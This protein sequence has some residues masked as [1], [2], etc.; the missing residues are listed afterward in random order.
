MKRFLSRGILALGIGIIA[1][2]TSHPDPLNALSLL[3]NL[4]S[5]SNLYSSQFP[6][7][8]SSSP[9]STTRQEWINPD[10]LRY[11]LIVHDLGGA[12]AIGDQEETQR[13]NDAKKLEEMV[14]KTY[15]VHTVLLPLFGNGQD[16]DAGNEGG[17]E[18]VK[19][20]QELERL[21]PSSSA[22]TNRRGGEVGLGVE[23]GYGVEPPQTPKT[24]TTG[25]DLTSRDI[26][27]LYR[28]M[29]EL[30]VQSIIPWIERSVVVGN[31]QVNSPSFSRS[32]SRFFSNESVDDVLL[33]ALN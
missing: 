32:F 18:D 7:P 13:W 33:N 30:V 19:R 29:R 3:W 15:G 5:P 17:E 11:V 28:F 26:D 6:L 20:C 2:S 31:E 25:R 12:G 22:N 10:L 21:F 16:Q 23:G 14:K 27:Q 24:L 1:L 4:T 9:S 8:P